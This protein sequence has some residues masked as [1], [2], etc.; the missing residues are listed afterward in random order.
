MLRRRNLS[1]GFC[2]H[3]RV[4][5]SNM[6]C[7]RRCLQI[8]RYRS[9]GSGNL[10]IECDRRRSRRDSNTVGR[11]R[12]HDAVGNTGVIDG[13]QKRCLES[14]RLHQLNRIDPNDKLNVNAEIAE[15]GNS[16]FDLMKR[17]GLNTVGNRDGCL[18]NDFFNLA[19]VNAV[20]N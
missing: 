9:G 5:C 1:D 20:W 18:F 13:V 7:G 2:T 12:H 16:A 15:T 14:I 4:C 17:V 10:S 8:G 11:S 19:E 6:T 3:R